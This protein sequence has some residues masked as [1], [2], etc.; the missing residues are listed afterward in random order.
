MLSL[1]TLYLCSSA[2][3]RVAFFA[4]YQPHLTFEKRR[5]YPTLQQN[6]ASNDW[7]RWLGVYLV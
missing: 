7:T 5:L 1:P 2:I 6:F 4:T 3:F